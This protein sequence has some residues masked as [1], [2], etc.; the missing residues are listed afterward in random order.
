[1]EGTKP[2]EVRDSK[3]EK[4]SPVSLEEVSCHVMR[5]SMEE[6][7]WPGSEGSL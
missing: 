6:A 2:A 4:D 1:M 7:M 3:C 5:G